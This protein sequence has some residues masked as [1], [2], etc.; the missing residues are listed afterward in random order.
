[1]KERHKARLW[2]MYVR[3]DSRRLGIGKALVSA[4]IDEAPQGIEQ[5]S[6][7][8]VEE[9]RSAISLYEALGFRAYGVERHALKVRDRY[10]DE[11]LMVRFLAPSPLGS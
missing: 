6:L 11:A 9:N 7:A 3:E 4:L 1:M 10:F 5:I 8:V 2:G